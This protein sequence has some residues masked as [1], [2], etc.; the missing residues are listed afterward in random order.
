M[1]PAAAR[2]AQPV[3]ARVAQLAAAPVVQLAAAQVAPPAAG[4]ES[5]EDAAG[6][7]GARE[8][9]AATAEVAAGVS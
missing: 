4:V 3:A 2:V 5:W 7:V 6:P 9:A 8:D 1:Q